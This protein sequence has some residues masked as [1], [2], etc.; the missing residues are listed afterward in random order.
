MTLPNLDAARP[1]GFH[2]DAPAENLL[3]S[4]FR[5]WM[6][7]YAT[8]DAACWDIAWEGLVREMPPA[9]AKPL[10]GEFHHFVRTLK[11]S[12]E[13]EIGWRPAACRA[14]CRDECLVLAM[15]DAAQRDD[16]VQLLNAASHLLKSEGLHQALEATTALAKALARVG[17]FIAPVTPG[18]LD[19]MTQMKP[20]SATAH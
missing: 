12:A 2:I 19:A 11:A 15:V 4:V 10:F 13:G 1:V 8:G 7:G 17:L 16:R 3:F 18:A 20:P 6:A 5:C 14:L 9:N